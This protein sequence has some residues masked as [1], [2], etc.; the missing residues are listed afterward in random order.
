MSASSKCPHFHFEANVE[1]ARIE[2][3]GLKY[4]HVTII[5]IDCGKPAVFRGLEIGVS[6]D[7]ATGDVEGKE[8]RLPFVLDPDDYNG[9]GLGYSIEVAP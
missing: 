3:T 5:C 1:V 2:D 6:P 8:A 7:H 4:A 9:N